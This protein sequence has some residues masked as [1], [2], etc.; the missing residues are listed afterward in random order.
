MLTTVAGKRKRNQL[1][2]ILLGVCC[3]LHEKLTL[4]FME[5]GYTGCFV[6]V[7]FGLV[8]QKFHR[9][10][11]FTLQQLSEIVYSSAACNTSQQVSQDDVP[12]HG[13]DAHLFTQFKA[14]KGIRT[15]QHFLFSSQKP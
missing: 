4:S 8:K 15:M 1:L 12:W 13:L 9:S 2:H 14:V 3:G 7:C 11:C 5:A 10:D 6:H